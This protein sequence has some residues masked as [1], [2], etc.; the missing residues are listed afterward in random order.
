METRE[1]KV[2]RPAPCPAYDVEGMESWLSDLSAEGLHLAPDGIFC[3]IA[4]FHRGEPGRMQYRLEA[5]RH[6]T[7]MW[8][9]QNGEPEE[10]ALE[11]NAEYGW[12]YVAK[13]G[14]FF[15]YR[16]AYDG[17]RELN[18]DPEV[19]AL[20][21]QAVRKRRRDALHTALFWMVVYPV[22]RSQGI[23]PVLL[24][25]I[26]MK[27]WL[28]LLTGLLLLWTI[29]SRLRECFALTRLYRRL[30]A[31]EEIRRGKDWRRRAALYRGVRMVDVVLTA[32]WAVLFA[33]TLLSGMANEGEIPIAAYAEE[34]PF[35]TIAD[36]AGEGADYELTNIGFANTV[37]RWSD[38]LAPDNVRWEE[39]G[40]VTGAD[41]TRIEGSLYVDYHET[42]HPRIARGLALEY[43]RHDRGQVRLTRLF[44]GENP[45]GEYEGPEPLPIS[46]DYAVGYRDDHG[47][48]HV[49]I[50]QGTRMVRASFHP[51]SQSEPLTMTQWAA[52]LAESIAE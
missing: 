25:A 20:A 5:S 29:V 24:M 27:S 51:Y 37:R 33:S 12:E 40:C 14:E 16:G 47:S 1:R 18:T 32:V 41:G 23:V 35:A 34:L 9:E 48:P 6:G 19:Q 46:A 42:V 26:H 22:A 13:R 15:I 43:L 49:L 8:N 4:E 45:F 7:S 36:F 30:R 10:E 50:C 52:I 2:F 44:S 39:I 17:E 21:L 3:G 28:M 11:L 38:W 31:G